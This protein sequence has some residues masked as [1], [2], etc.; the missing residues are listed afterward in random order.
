MSTAVANANRGATT[1]YYR[2]AGY[3]A[4]Q[5]VVQRTGPNITDDYEREASKDME[6][7]DT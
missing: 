3:V 6:M 5:P 4:Q 7:T 2:P 1:N